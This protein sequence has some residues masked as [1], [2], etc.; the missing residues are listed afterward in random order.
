MSGGFSARL[1]LALCALA[2]VAGTSAGCGDEGDSTAEEAKT[3]F[4]AAAEPPKVFMRRMGNLLATT[5][6]KKDC[7]QLEEINQRSYVRFPCPPSKDLRTSMS[8][9]KVVGA[10]EYGTGAVVDYRSGKIKDGATVLL[11]VA[12]DRNWGISRFGVITEPSTKS[13]DDE[14]RDG[15]QETV[16]DYLAA[17]RERDCK[18]FR[19]V[20][21]ISPD[22]KDGEVCGKLFAGT[23]ELA[24]RMKLQPDAKPVYQGGNDTYGFF[25]FETI[26]TDDNSTISVVRSGSG[27]DA[28]YVVLDVTPSPTT[29]EQRRVER[30]YRRQLKSGT[31]TGSSKA[32]LPQEDGPA[33]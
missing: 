24:E 22:V 14:S 26:E 30:E 13:S 4:S 27:D 5:S 11:Y 3:Q 33:N 32:P 31:E 7:P 9:F 10:A 15:Y 1:G 21:Y 12:P 19:E 2:V 18:A 6:A 23:K 25:S 28:S 17:V 8:K 20:A 16:D 29:V